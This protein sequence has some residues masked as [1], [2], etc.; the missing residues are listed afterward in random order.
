MILLYEIAPL[1]YAFPL[2][3]VILVL[4]AKRRRF[5][6]KTTA[7]LFIL[8]GLTYFFAVYI[9]FPPARFSI[10]LSYYYRISLALLWPL[11][12][13]FSISSSWGKSEFDTGVRLSLWPDALFIF[14][15]GYFSFIGTS[16][17]VVPDKSEAIDIQ[18]PLR[19]GSFFISCGGSSIFQNHHAMYGDSQS[20]GYDIMQLN[21]SKNS[22]IGFLSSKPSD[23][24]IHST[25]VYSPIDGAVISVV[26]SVGEGVP[27]NRDSQGGA[28]NY[29][30]IKRDSISILLAHL[31]K[32]SIAASVGQEVK[33]GQ[34]LGKVGLSGDANEPHLHIHAYKGAPSEMISGGIPVLIL[35]EGD[36]LKRADVVQ[37]VKHK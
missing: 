36:F 13:I 8:F 27:H 9:T 5:R 12:F 3:P 37:V 7:Y 26:D 15:I 2:V 16:S 6:S 28:G 35:F 29:V 14:L 25:D 11:L 4:V 24:F 1:L 10:P 30:L 33:A 18:F 22:S 23:Y 21:E 34:F 19:D 32:G 20:Y 31:L 17:L